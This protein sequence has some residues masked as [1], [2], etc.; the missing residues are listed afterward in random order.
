MPE[1]SLIAKQ[2]EVTLEEPP[3]LAELVEDVVGDV[4]DGCDDA[5]PTFSPTYV[6]PYY[7]YG[8]DENWFQLSHMTK[9]NRFPKIFDSA[10]KLQPNPQR[11]LSFGCST[12]QEC[13]TL[14]EIY[15][16]AEIVGVDIDFQSIRYARRNNKND[17]IFYHTDLGATGKYDLA[18]CLMVFFRLEQSIPFEQMANQLKKIDKYL[19]KEAL[20]MI[21]TSDHDPALVEEIGKY[22]PVNTWKHTHNKNQKEYFDGY[23]RKK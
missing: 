10:K 6:A 11:I 15:P 9:L 2:T 16:E 8:Q 21:Y 3:V 14:A 17:R 18:L 23:Y 13:E 5:S 7:G 1:I 22:E 4:A 20:L 12:G 19:N